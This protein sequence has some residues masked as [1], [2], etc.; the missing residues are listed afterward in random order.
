MAV[1]TTE[2]E[3]TKHVEFLQKN[4]THDTAAGLRTMTKKHYYDM[5]ASDGLTPEIIESVVASDARVM[6]AA[7][8]VATDD[9]RVQIEKAREAG[10]DTSGL[11]ST[12]RISTPGGS[13]EVEVM[14]Q[15]TRKNPRTGEPIT[16]YGAVNADIDAKKRLPHDAMQR[17]QTL[18]TKA[19]GLDDTAITA[20]AED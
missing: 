14:A 15:R 3:Y 8:H 7:T 19:L 12:V 2:S 18:I 20:A 5:I 16:K 6:G 10:D 13:T 11:K 4:S 1:K 9:L 17:A